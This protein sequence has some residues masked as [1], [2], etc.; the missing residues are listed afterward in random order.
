MFITVSI[1]IGAMVIMVIAEVIV[2]V[3][4]LPLFLGVLLRVRR[5]RL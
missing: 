3:A 5:E 4:V 2:I 1:V